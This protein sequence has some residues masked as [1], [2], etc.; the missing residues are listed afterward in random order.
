M[1]D[2]EIKHYLEKIDKSIQELNPGKAYNFLMKTGVYTKS[3]KLK[4]V[5][6]N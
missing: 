5:Y 1:T 3:G 4:K 6:K 2:S